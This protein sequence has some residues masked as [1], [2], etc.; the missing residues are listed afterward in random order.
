M[1]IRQHGDCRT[2]TVLPATASKKLYHRSCVTGADRHTIEAGVHPVNVRHHGNCSTIKMLPTTEHHNCASTSMPIGN[3]KPHPKT[4]MQPHTA[5]M[6]HPATTR[7]QLAQAGPAP[8]PSAAPPPPSPPRAGWSLQ[9]C[10]NLLVPLCLSSTSPTSAISTKKSD[11]E[12][13]IPSFPFL[14]LISC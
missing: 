9:L 5:C 14:K 4:C 12:S 13:T 11:A 6:K 3:F 1:N 8:P 2:I 7:S 10:H